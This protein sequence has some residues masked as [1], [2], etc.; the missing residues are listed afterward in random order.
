MMDNLPVHMR[1]SSL[2]PTND[3]VDARRAAIQELSTAW[4]KIRDVETILAKVEEIAD[5]LGGDG[6][7]YDDLG[8]EVQSAVQKHASAFLYEESP[9][10]VGI[11]AGMAAITMIGGAPGSTGWTTADVYS[12][13]LWSALSFQ[14]PIGEAKRE[15]L[16]QEVLEAAQNRSRAVADKARE[17]VAVPDMGDLAVTIDEEGKASTT[18]KKSVGATVENLRRNAALDR[19]ELDFLWWVQLNRSRLLG[20]SMSSMAEPLRL[21]ASGIEAALHLRR[22]P[23]DVHFDIVSRT[24]EEDPELD[25]IGLL[26]V[27]GED[28]SK[29]AAA[30]STTFSSE[31]ATVF[32]LIN[33]LAT[34]ETDVE[35][36]KIKRTASAWGGRALLE[37]GLSRMSDLGMPKL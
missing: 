37:A 5:S 22:M 11:C 17:R 12:N 19:E 28:R 29:L 23:A 1:I 4:G 18:F 24:I 30:V 6:Q 8:A 21:L 9:L 33:A 7:R 14:E 34:G 25:L 13:G 3:D 10:D 26:E 27:V 16:R 15:R 36:A 31:H 20:K 2:T 32:P 35:G